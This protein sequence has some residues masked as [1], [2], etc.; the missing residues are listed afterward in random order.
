MNSELLKAM[1]TNTVKY[2]CFDFKR[3]W[4]DYAK[5]LSSSESVEF[6]RAVLFYGF[7]ETEPTLADKAQTFFN[8]YVRA[9][10]DAQHAKTRTKKHC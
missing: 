9:D 1:D 4:H 7:S 8:A 5:T 6:Y 3:S 2:P 10:L